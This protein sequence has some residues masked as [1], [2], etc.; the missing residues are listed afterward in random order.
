MVEMST[1]RRPALG[2]PTLDRPGASESS[3]CSVW[4]DMFVGVLMQVCRWLWAVMRS[5]KRCHRKNVEASA[6][7][8][9]VGRQKGRVVCFQEL[10]LRRWVQY[11]IAPEELPVLQPKKL[12]A[13]VNMILV[14][15]FDVKMRGVVILGVISVSVSLSLFLSLSPCLP[16]CL[17]PGLPVSLFLSPFSSLPVP[18]LSVSLC[19]SPFSWLPL[20]LS[21][22]L[23]LPSSSRKSVPAFQK[24]MS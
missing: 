10:G 11:S 8:K 2:G 18:L 9:E 14:W 5:Q 6:S 13:T 17:F 16:L 22:R 19:L 24:Q 21:F 12:E 15:D 7:H 3:L 20:Y 23:S 1:L 4:V